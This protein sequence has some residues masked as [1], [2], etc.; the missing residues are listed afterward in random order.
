MEA[1]QLRDAL[2]KHMYGNEELLNDYVSALLGGCNILLLGAPGK[3]KSTLVEITARLIGGKYFRLQG[4]PDARMTSV[5]HINVAE[6]HKG[7][8]VVVWKREFLEADII[9]VPSNGHTNTYNEGN[10]AV[11]APCQDIQHVRSA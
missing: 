8:E 2:S 4:S 7:N 5:A 9:I 11:I 3:A 10:E 1:K 6:L